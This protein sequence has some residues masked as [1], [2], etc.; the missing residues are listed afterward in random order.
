MRPVRM[1]LQ[2]RRCAGFTLVELVVTVL[3]VSLLCAVA[4]PTYTNQVRKGQRAECRGALLQS[5]LQQER[6][7][8]QHHT[9]AAF[10][11][12][13]PAAATLSFSGASPA[14]SACLIEAAP[15]AAAPPSPVPAMAQ[16]VE[17]RGSL[18]NDPAVPLLYL[19]SDN[20]KGCTHQG[21]ERVTGSPACWE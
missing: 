7:Y 15:C 9:Y 8:T 1:P 12:G 18:R 10:A 4:Y 21:R 13:H 20:E 11:S 16:C 2:V 3:V 19:T 5:M 14:S 6:H 17:L